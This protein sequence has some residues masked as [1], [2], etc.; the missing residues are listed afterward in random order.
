MSNTAQEY[1][2][3]STLKAV[4]S[5][6]DA[7]LGLP[8]DK[9]N[10]SPGGEARTA[11]DMVAECALMNEA[12]IDLLTTKVFDESFDF[13]EYNRVRAELTQDWPTLQARLHESAARV[14][15]TIRA[16]P[17]SDLSIEVPMPWGTSTIEGICGY[18][19]WNMSYH[20]GQ[21]TQIQMILAVPSVDNEV[22]T[23]SD[24]P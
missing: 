19:Y 1:L 18:P 8:E 4:K 15:E 24:K 20:E 17:D 2:V 11:L 9:R 22:N 7:L 10:W 12:T 16:V 21:I 6:E 13:A 3:R 14:T 23:V 5:I